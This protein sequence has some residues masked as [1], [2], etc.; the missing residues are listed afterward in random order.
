LEELTTITLPAC[1]ITPNECPDGVI[2][3]LTAMETK[4]PTNLAKI[5]K[6]Q[7]NTFSGLVSS[8]DPSIINKSFRYRLDFTDPG[9][10][11]L[12]PLNPYFII[13]VKCIVKQVF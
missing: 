8:K 3:T 11:V 12:P 5:V 9:G 7:S 2:G 6:D 1:S 10:I 13:T 4:T